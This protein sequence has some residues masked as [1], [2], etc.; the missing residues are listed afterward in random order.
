MC[1]NAPGTYIVAFNYRRG[2]DSD[3]H[4]GN[5]LISY[6]CRVISSVRGTS[7][8]VFG[9]YTIHRRTRR[10]IFNGIKVAGH[11]GAS[12]PGAIITIY[13]YV[14]RRRRVTSGLGGD[15]P[16]ISVMVNARMDR[17]LPRFLCGHL[18]NR[19]E[20]FRL[21]VSGGAVIRSMP[22]GHSNAFGN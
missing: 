2:M 17:H 18:S 4:L 10:H 19:G 9:A 11:V 16:C 7:F 3:R 22:I 20:V 13:N 14:M 15:C 5:V 21:S 12:E 1:N 6:N 8:V